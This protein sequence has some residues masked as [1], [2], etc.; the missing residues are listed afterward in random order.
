MNFIQLITKF[1]NIYSN[2]N[3]L[4]ENIFTNFNQDIIY[5]LYK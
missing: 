3:S 4:I 5:N 2:G 1:T